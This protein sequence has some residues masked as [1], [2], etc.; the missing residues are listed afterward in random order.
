[1]QLGD[2]HDVTGWIAQLHDSDEAKREEAEE[3]L[4][5]RY[6]NL[7][8]HAV[9][10]ELTPKLKAEVDAE[11]AAQSALRSF[12]SSPVSSI[13]DRNSLLRWL[14]EVVGNKR[15]DQVRY[16]T[17]AKRDVARKVSLD[18]LGVSGQG[19]SDQ[20]ALD[21]LNPRYTIHRCGS[22]SRRQPMP[23]TR[24]APASLSAMHKKHRSQRSR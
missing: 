12:F 9:R 2:E 22:S 14:L 24:R 23:L 15:V 17:A 20:A 16:A 18:Q 5:E 21:H 4:F 3:R 7:L 8:R 11:I 13:Q 1:M 10:A 19:D 6:V